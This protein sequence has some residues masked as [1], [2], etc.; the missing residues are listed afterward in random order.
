MKNIEPKAIL[1]GLLTMLGISVVVGYLLAGTAVETHG[2]VATAIGLPDDFD[3]NVP[4]IPLLL[5]PHYLPLVI[6]MSI[7]T[8][9]IP[10]YVT[11]VVAARAPVLNATLL[12]ACV[13]PFAWIGVESIPGALF[14]TGMGAFDLGIAWLAGRL[15]QWYVR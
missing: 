1:I 10:A 2:E 3:G 9:G 12:G 6:G 11:A 13:L 14:A 8:I 4:I 7:A 5:H 15:R